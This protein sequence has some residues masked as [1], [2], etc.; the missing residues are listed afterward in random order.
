MEEADLVD[1]MDTFVKS[2]KEFN[3]NTEEIMEQL[4]RY[5]GNLNKLN[6]CV[7]LDLSMKNK[8]LYLEFNGVTEDR[9]IPENIQNVFLNYL[10]P[11]IENVFL[12]IFYRSTIISILYIGIAYYGNISKEFNTQLNK[13]TFNKLPWKRS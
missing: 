13:F 3:E 7:L 9:S 8:K 12:D 10:F 5:E 1:R 6:T 2:I 11:Q 4:D